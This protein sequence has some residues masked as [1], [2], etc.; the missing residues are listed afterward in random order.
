MAR[1]RSSAKTA[2]YCHSSQEERGVVLHKSAF[3]QAL[4]VMRKPSS[5]KCPRVNAVPLRIRAKRLSMRRMV[6]ISLGLRAL[7]KLP[8]TRLANSLAAVSVGVSMGTSVTA[9][10]LGLERGPV[11][12]GFRGVGGRAAASV[13]AVGLALGFIRATLPHGASCASDRKAGSVCESEALGCSSPPAHGT[14]STECCLDGFA[15]WFDG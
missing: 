14:L 6:S 9:A 13:R 7:P 10:G 8:A 5:A 1:F 2:M 4:S 15:E 12:P 11:R 3:C